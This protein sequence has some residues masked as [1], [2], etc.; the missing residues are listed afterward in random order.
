MIDCHIQII[1]GKFKLDQTFSSEH[2]VI[3]LFGASGSGE[4]SILH[5]IAGLNTPVK[6]GLK[7]IIRHGSMLKIRSI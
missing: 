5:A 4:T 3:G 6:A 7:S 2:H 1:L